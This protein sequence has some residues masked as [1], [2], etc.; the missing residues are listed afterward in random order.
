M[1]R[2][3][4]LTLSLSSVMVLF[5]ACGNADSSN[6]FNSSNELGSQTT[7]ANGKVEYVDYKG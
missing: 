4:L 5:T 7:L 3:L 1:K 6:E 2:N